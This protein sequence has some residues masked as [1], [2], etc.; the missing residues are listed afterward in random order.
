MTAV[1]LQNG[2][3]IRIVLILF[4][5]ILLKLFIPLASDAVVIAS[6]ISNVN[7]LFYFAVLICSVIPSKF[8]WI[9]ACLTLVIASILDLVVFLLSFIVTVRCL[10]EGGCIQ[11]L[12]FSLIVLGLTGLIALLDLYQT[13]NVYL[14][15]Q[16]KTYVASATQRLRVVLTWSIPFVLLTNITMVANSEFSVFGIVPLI[17]LPIVIFLAHKPEGTFLGLL[18]VITLISIAATLFSVASSLASSSLLI[19]GILTA[20]G[21]VLLFMPTEYYTKP[22]EP[23]EPDLHI[24]PTF[25]IEKREPYT[26]FK[27]S[28]A[29]MPAAQLISNNVKEPL[30]R[31]RTKNSDGKLKF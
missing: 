30:L 12:P 23:A 25:T 10:D 28:E 16:D 22:A 31:Q 13:W 14:I 8:A 24:L 5:S 9:I 7:N 18:L 4:I 29:L 6:S 11:T 15:L 2:V 19:E 27:A 26:D 3:R 1:E 21:F 20:F 17:S